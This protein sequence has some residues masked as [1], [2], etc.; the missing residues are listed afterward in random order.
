MLLD[1]LFLLALFW[2]MIADVDWRS[3]DAGWASPA[4]V[5]EVVRLRSMGDSL[6]VL[7]VVVLKGLSWAAGL[8]VLQERLVELR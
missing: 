7:L 3:P 4:K 2:L 6:A 5:R 8:G 1:R